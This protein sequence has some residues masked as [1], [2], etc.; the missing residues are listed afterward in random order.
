MFVGSVGALS[1]RDPGPVVAARVKSFDPAKNL[2]EEE[3][4]HDSK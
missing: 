3:H 2:V 4:G 1:A